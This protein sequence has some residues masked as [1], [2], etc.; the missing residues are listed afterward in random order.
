MI[1]GISIDGFPIKAGTLK[2]F[3]ST[4]IIFS[5]LE[6]GLAEPPPFPDDRREEV[7]RL[8]GAPGRPALPPVLLLPPTVPNLLRDW[9]VRFRLLLLP[10]RLAMALGSLSGT[11]SPFII[12]GIVHYS[13]GWS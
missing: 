1:T 12:T 5:K 10:P 13:Q 8:P 11:T 4:P 7:P 3:P 9:E 6:S 2:V